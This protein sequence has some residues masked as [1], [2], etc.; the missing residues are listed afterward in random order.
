MRDLR[1]TIQATAL[2]AATLLSG[3]AQPAA[4]DGDS[5][6]ICLNADLP[7]LS[8]EAAIIMSSGCPGDHTAT[9][10]ELGLGYRPAIETFR[11]AVAWLRAAGHLSEAPQA[12][13]ART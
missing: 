2:L 6:R 3:T 8:E 11:D 10:T 9:L 4:A 5:L 12:G 1:G 7:P 13:G